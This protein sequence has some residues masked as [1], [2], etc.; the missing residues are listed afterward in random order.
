MDSTAKHVTQEERE[1]DRV[2]DD[3]LEILLEDEE[4]ELFEINL[5][6]VNNIPPL[7]HSWETYVTVNTA[8]ATTTTTNE[9]T[10][11]GVAHALLANC[12]LPVTDLSCA[13]P[14]I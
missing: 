11:W 4:E 9:T 13:M 5:E 6:H 14:I 2:V 8:A 1:I 7:H 12:L 10:P 3:G